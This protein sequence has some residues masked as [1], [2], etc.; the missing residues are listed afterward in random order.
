MISAPQLKLQGNNAP[1][2]LLKGGDSYWIEY[3]VSALLGDVPKSEYSYRVSIFDPCDDID[4]LLGYLN[5]YSFSEDGNIAVARGRKNKLTAA[6]TK[7]LKAYCSSP[8]E[9]NK[10]IICDSGN[11]FD[12]IAEYCA[13]ISCEALPADK[14]GDFAAKTAAD[15]GLKIDGAALRFLCAQCN[16]ELSRIV[17][18]LK[19]L[20]D[21]G[22]QGTINK[23]IVSMLVA[24]DTGA[25]AYELTDAL[26]AGRKEQAADILAKMC[27]SGT[28]PAYILRVLSGAYRNLLHARISGLDDN[29]LSGALG[30]SAYAARKIKK[31]AAK[32][33][34]TT[35]KSLSDC[36]NDLEYHFKSGR[37]SADNALNL[38]VGRLMGANV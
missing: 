30:I 38:A 8:S 37:I 13:V 36:L 33:S 9:S 16:N 19:K 29:A 12:C 2:Y 18:E 23:D 4:E 6:D 7:A 31:V 26:S 10:L 35:L 14:V 3:A 34:A 17:P 20:L 21:Y 11:I 28:A 32:Y 15:M 24:P 5:C 27:E 25:K 22:E 1:V